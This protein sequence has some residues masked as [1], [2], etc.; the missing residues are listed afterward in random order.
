MFLQPCSDKCFGYT[1]EKFFSIF[2]NTSCICATEFLSG[3]PYLIH[4]EWESTT[5]WQAAFSMSQCSNAIDF[6][7]EG[8]RLSV[9]HLK[10]SHCSLLWRRLSYNLFK[11]TWYLHNVQFTLILK[12]KTIEKETRL[13]QFQVKPFWLVNHL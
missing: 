4:L 11:M 9:G 6:W 5:C 7:R 10:I 3:C 1:V 8:K 12:N 13:I 2:W